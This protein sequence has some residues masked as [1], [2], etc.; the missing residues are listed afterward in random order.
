MGWSKP[1]PK[2]SVSESPEPLNVL[3]YMATGT[4]HYVIKRTHLEKVRL[5]QITWWYLVIARVLK[6]KMKAEQKVREE[7]VTM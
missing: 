6:W 7:D 3:F 5:Y 4:L 2:I 1:L